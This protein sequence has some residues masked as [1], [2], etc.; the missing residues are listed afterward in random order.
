M[1]MIDILWTK[2]HCRGAWTDFSEHIDLFQLIYLLVID[3]NV[4]LV[5]VL[6]LTIRRSARKLYSIDSVAVRYS[7]NLQK[8]FHEC[9]DSRSVCA[10]KRTNL[11]TTNEL[12]FIIT[13]HSFLISSIAVCVYMFFFICLVFFFVCVHDSVS[14]NRAL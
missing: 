6:I 14:M 8:N 13:L 7:S 12:L 11:L 1:A 3:C 10:M 5:R 9:D 4:K 2:C